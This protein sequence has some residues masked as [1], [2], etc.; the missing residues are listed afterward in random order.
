[1]FRRN[2]IRHPTSSLMQLSQPR[3]G[4][5]SHGDDFRRV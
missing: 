5:N 4:R 3:L 2:E 1:V